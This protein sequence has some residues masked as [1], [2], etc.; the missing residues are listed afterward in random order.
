MINNNIYKI[1]IVLCVGIVTGVFRW[2]VFYQGYLEP[3]SFRSLDIGKMRKTLVR[4]I[5][6]QPFSSVNRT[7][8]RIYPVEGPDTHSVG[9]ILGEEAY[10]KYAEQAFGLC[11]TIFNYGCYHGVV[12]MAIRVHG[13]DESL[14]KKLYESCERTMV[15][16]GPCIH[17][18]GHA[19]TIIAQYNILRAF[20]ICDE[21]Y[22]DSKVAFSCWQGAMM[23][24]INRASL[25]APN[26]PYGD[27]NDLYYP[28]STFHQKY[29]AACVSSHVSYVSLALAKDYKKILDYC[30]SYQDFEVQSRCIDAVGTLMGQ[31]YFSKPEL[32]IDICSYAGM[33][34][35]TCTLGAVVPF[36]VAKKRES[37]ILLCDTLKEGEVKNACYHRF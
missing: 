24:Y 10:K 11:D 27:P 31:E 13:P 12:D 8:H 37:V 7:L 21:V 30:H 34:Q 22:P 28:C 23:E 16:S 29:M 26:E 17:P 1:V 6:V 25:A 14:I 5:Q 15:D 4:I 36:A 32:I 19:A 20:D 35:E 33:Y 9:H 3:N 2:V 18:L